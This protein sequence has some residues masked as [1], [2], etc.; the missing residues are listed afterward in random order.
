MRRRDA[1]AALSRISRAPLSHPP[2]AHACV[3][4]VDKAEAIQGLRE[5][6]VEAT[7]EELGGIFEALD[8]DHSGSFDAEEMKL[9][10]KRFQE[11]RNEWD[12]KLKELSKT[13]RELRK[14]ASVAQQ[15]ALAMEAE[16]EQA[17]G[18]ADHQP[19][20]RRRSQ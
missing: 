3:P 14:A 19:R 16:D 20:G 7:D 17:A 6:G 4:P 11:E 13:E 8:V 1:A 15:S 5:I 2:A 12:G 18:G 9:A 10:F